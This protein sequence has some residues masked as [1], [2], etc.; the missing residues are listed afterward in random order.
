M[1]NSRVI[2]I[3]LVFSRRLFYL[4]EVITDA[5]RFQ[6]ALKHA[7]I[8]VNDVNCSNRVILKPEAKFR[9]TGKL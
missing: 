5:V 1:F 4:T 9:K 6:V 8:F 2:Q 3:T 7:E